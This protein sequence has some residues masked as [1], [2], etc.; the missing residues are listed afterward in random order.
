MRLVTY[1]GEGG[2]RPGVVDAGSGTVRPVTAAVDGGAVDVL[3]IVERWDDVGARL[4]LGDAVPLGEVTLLAPFRP[5]RDVM[6]VGKNY[7]DHSGEFARSGFDATG[8]GPADEIPEHPIVFTKSAGSVVGTGT[9]IE[10]HPGLTTALDYEIE[11]A[12]IIGRGGRGITAERVGEHVWGYTIVNDVTARDLQRAHRQWFIGKSLDTFCPMGPWAVSA[13]EVDVMD[14]TVT[15]RVNG[16][17]RQQGNT[18]DLIFDVP[19][20]VSTISAGITLRPGDVIATGTPAG[21]GIGFD[22]P[23]FLSPGDVVEAEITGLGTL[24]N[25]VADVS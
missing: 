6:C 4:T 10:P 24:T 1:L 13:D 2:E 12:V 19:T 20:L 16:E 15:C 8:K 21:V 11:L 9:A 17:V 5:P 7:R 3:G 18:R 14:L 22:P 25:R 23:R